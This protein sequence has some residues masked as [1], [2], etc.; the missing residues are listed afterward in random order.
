[1]KLFNWVLKKFAK[2]VRLG[3]ATNSSSSH[4]LVFYKQPIYGHDVPVNSVVNYETEFGWSGSDLDTLGAKLT[5]GLVALLQ[6]EGAQTRWWSDDDNSAEV[7][8]VFNEYGHLFPEFTLEDF[9]EAANGYIDHQ[10]ESKFSE[11]FLEDL[12]NPNSVVMIGN[13]N[14]E[15]YE[16]PYIEVASGRAESFIRLGLDGDLYS[17]EGRITKVKKRSSPWGDDWYIDDSDTEEE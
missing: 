17:R 6:S 9:Q 3:L 8:R 15:S 13:D 1:M 14:G 7:V 4:S 16:Y 10:S 2:N 12:R 5:Y 11:E